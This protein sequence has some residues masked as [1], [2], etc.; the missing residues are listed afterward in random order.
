VKKVAIVG[1]QE[2]TRDKAPFDDPSYGIW[3]FADWLC[4][5]W[6]KR[7]DA[8]MEIHLANV[9]TNHPRT[10]QYWDALQKTEIPV[11]MYPVADPR[12]P[13][14]ILYPLDSVLGLVAK[15]KNQG[16]SFKPFNSTVAYAL[17]L[18]ILYE[19]DVIDIYGVELANPSER[20]SKQ[21]EIFAFW[22]GVALG[23]GIELNVNCSD[24]LFVQPLY[25]SE[26]VIPSAKLYQYLSALN[27]DIQIYQQN[28]NMAIGAKNMIQQLLGE[29]S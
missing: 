10:P 13:N 3:G 6:M 27:S 18:A 5:P 8:L 17:G 20:F 24:G 19:Y 14:S 1:A 11:F 23:R 4:A 15:G 26:D 7:C 29:G 25:G 21:S 12:V 28:A 2:M 22:N 16:K 9:Y